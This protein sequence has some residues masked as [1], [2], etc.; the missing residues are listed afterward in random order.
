MWEKKK[1]KHTDTKG[2]AKRGEKKKTEWK[3][4]KYWKIQKDRK[5]HERMT[6][7]ERD[8]VFHACNFWCHFC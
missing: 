8:Q 3:K 6:G 5:E 1:H 7:T 2:I 4:E